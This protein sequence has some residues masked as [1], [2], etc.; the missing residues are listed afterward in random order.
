M[1]T[2]TKI[3]GANNLANHKIQNKKYVKTIHY[4][5]YQKVGVTYKNMY[6]WAKAQKLSFE[7]E[8]IEFY[9]NDP[10]NTEKQSIETMVLI[11]IANR[12]IGRP[13]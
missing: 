3:E 1:P 5:P 8:F 6:A 7:N 2:S 4:G 10:K 11:P 13:G 9:L 12:D